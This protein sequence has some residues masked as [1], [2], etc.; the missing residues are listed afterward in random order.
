MVGFLLYISA[1]SPGTIIK[2]TEISAGPQSKQI[3][4][5]Y[6]VDNLSINIPKGTFDYIGHGIYLPFGDETEIGLQE[7]I[8]SDP[9]EAESEFQN[10]YHK[11]RQIA[12]NSNLPNARSNISSLDA[13]LECPSFLLTLFDATSDNKS[14]WGIS[15]RA[16]VKLDKGFLLFSYLSQDYDFKEHKM[17]IEE[18]SNDKSTRLILWLKDFFKRYRWVGQDQVSI[19][20][21]YR[22]WLGLLSLSN[23]NVSNPNFMLFANRRDDDADAYVE[24][25]IEDSRLDDHL[26]NC[27]ETVKQF[28][29][30]FN[31]NARHD[32]PFSFL[33]PFRRV[34]NRL[35]IVAVE[36][37]DE[38][39]HKVTWSELPPPEAQVLRNPLTI[40]MTFLYSANRPKDDRRKYRYLWEKII[41]NVT[42][43]ELP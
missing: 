18:Y 3:N 7:N 23:N 21:N 14:D 24:L 12:H 15:L 1:L 19:G 27:E 43:I 28:I 10:E 41:N 36:N 42:E 5:I 30:R 6:Y 26:Q 38:I 2:A 16:W 8:F 39:G 40:E 13:I 37:F 22:T 34:G 25:I 17:D 9:A 31:D 4:E 35:G 29:R 20:E 32:E 33:F 11:A